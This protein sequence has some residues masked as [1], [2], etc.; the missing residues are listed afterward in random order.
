MVLQGRQEII[1]RRGRALDKWVTKKK[2]RGDYSTG[3]NINI[4]TKRYH[5]Y[6]SLILLAFNVSD[7]AWGNLPMA[8]YAELR[9]K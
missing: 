8:L 1:W 2:T 9:F 4:P 5:T 6:Q 7:F 3:F